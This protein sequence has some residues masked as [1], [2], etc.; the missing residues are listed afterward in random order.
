[1]SDPGN[2]HFVEGLPQRASGP[3]LQ[4][5]ILGSGHYLAE[6][7]RF[8]ASKAASLGTDRFTTIGIVSAGPQDGKTTVAIG[9]AAAL[10]RAST[11]RVMLLEADLRK[12]C[13]ERYLGLPRT[14]GV[15]EWLAGRSSSVPV[16]TVSPPGFAVISGGRERLARPELL[17][18][19]RM[20]SLI[21]ACQL[22]YGFIVVD[23]PPLDPVADAVAIQ[24]LLD[25]FL[26]VVR[27]R[28]AS[29]EATERALGRLKA[30]R[31][32]GIVFNGQSSILSRRYY[33]QKTSY[34]Q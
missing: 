32:Q 13:I 31:V 17:G 14:S 12:P 18:S 34:Q 23:C 5:A 26:L 15:A 4:Q 25:G 2:V 7:F 20:A 6:E 28:S 24:D 8:L 3:P 29:R 21:G 9:L 16:R 1:M 19:Q 10:A 22:S 27:A 30:N 11:H 33:R